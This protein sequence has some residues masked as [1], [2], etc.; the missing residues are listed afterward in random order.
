MTV[1]QF[2]EQVVIPD[3]RETLRRLDGQ[4]ALITQL[5]AT[6]QVQQPPQ[7]PPQAQAQEPAPAAAAPV[8]AQARRRRAPA[9]VQKRKQPERKCKKEGKYN[10]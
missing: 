1:Q 9:R 7:Q 5:I 10:A 8:Q 3:Q 6:V 4:G 2:V